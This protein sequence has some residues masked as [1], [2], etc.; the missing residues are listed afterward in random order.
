[1]VA[2]SLKGYSSGYR[3]GNLNYLRPLK[4]AYP[5]LPQYQNYK[6]VSVILDVST[7]IKI[8][9]V[10]NLMFTPIWSLKIYISSLFR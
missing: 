4:D 1:M 10:N 5:V 7:G 9:G 6:R 3:H 8:P 2:N